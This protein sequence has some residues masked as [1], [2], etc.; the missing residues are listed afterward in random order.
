MDLVG[1][2]GSWGRGEWME[3]EE[4]EAWGGEGLPCP[5]LDALSREWE[6]SP[7]QLSWYGV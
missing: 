4:T 1:V 2:E 6:C 7:A 5:V 3:D